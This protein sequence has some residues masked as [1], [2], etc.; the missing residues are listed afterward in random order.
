MNDKYN[1][2]VKKLNKL[3]PKTPLEALDNPVLIDK[4]KK[5]LLA[6]K[7]VNLNKRQKI[8][9]TVLTE[10]SLKDKLPL[11][12]EDDNVA[13]ID[14]DILNTIETTKPN[15]NDITSQSGIQVGP[16]IFCKSVINPTSTNIDNLFFSYNPYGDLTK[17]N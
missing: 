2:Y 16:E 1:Y 8:D 7:T 14:R 9:Y 12:G 5:Q 10:T 11:V 3:S 4:T 13:K 17:K 15:N 6:T